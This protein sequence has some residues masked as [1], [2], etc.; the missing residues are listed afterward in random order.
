MKAVVV[1]EVHHRRVDGAHHPAVQVQ[2]GDKV[3]GKE[4]GALADKVLRNHGVDQ[5]VKVEAEAGVV[6]DI[7]NVD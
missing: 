3:V 7:K 6:E 1:G 2:D 4:V 5:V